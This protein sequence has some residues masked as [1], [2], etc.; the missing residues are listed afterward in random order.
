MPQYFTNASRSGRVR[1]GEFHL[2]IAVLSSSTSHLPIGV[3]TPAGQTARGIAKW[4]LRVHGAIVP[5]LFVVI[6]G[7]FV[8]VEPAPD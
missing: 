5:G 8:P 6:D 1:F 4:L 2:P 7:E 3:A